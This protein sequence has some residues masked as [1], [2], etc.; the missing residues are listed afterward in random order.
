MSIAQCL[1]PSEIETRTRLS[2]ALISVS[3]ASDSAQAPGPR[4]RP[5]CGR[6]RFQSTNSPPPDGQNRARQSLKKPKK[7][8]PCRS[9]VVSCLGQTS[10]NCTFGQEW[11]YHAPHR[12][13]TTLAAK[14]RA[15]CLLAAVVSGGLRAASVWVWRRHR[16]T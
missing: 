11:D 7:A 8:A 3:S 10:D 4:P 6:L 1:V 5:V 13:S 15:F 2:P 12:Q 14:R 16:L 9:P